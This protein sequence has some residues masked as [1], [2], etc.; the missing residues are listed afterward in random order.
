MTRFR[1]ALVATA[2]LALAAGVAPARAQVLDVR[3]DALDAGE[4][5]A[6]AEIVADVR[7]RLPPAWSAGIEGPL[8]VEWGDD[9]PAHVE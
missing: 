7:A 4:R 5:A 9:L 3:T 2:A 8:R 1:R 6:S